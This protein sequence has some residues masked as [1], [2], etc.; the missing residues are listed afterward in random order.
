MKNYTFNAKQ[1]RRILI[2]LTLIITAVAVADHLP[3]DILQGPESADTEK[4]A[5]VLEV[6]TDPESVESVQSDTVSEEITSAA[7]T[8]ESAP[9]TSAPAGELP[10][11]PSDKDTLAV[12]LLGGCAPGSPLGTATFGSLNALI[13]R[14]GADY[15]FRALNALLTSDDLTI[16]A[17]NCVFTDTLPNGTLSCAAPAGNAEIYS[18]GSVEFLSLA[19]PIFTQ[20]TASETASALEIKNLKSGT[21]GS[22]AF[23]E[24][25]D[26]TL[27][28]YCTYLTKGH[29]TAQDL[30]ALRDAKG[31]SDY[32]IVFFWQ[33]ATLS[34]EPEEWM[35]Y[36]L[37]HFADEGASLIVGCGSNVLQP[38]ENYRESTIAYSIGTVL[39]G[40]SFLSDHS[41]A[42]LR[43]QLKRGTDGKVSSEILLIPCAPSVNRWQ[44]Y[45]LSDGER[46]SEVLA[47]LT[48]VTE[49]PLTDR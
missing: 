17:N 42:A 27:A 16:A 30:Q 46:K 22:T 14:E 40:T 28:V 35:R 31:K 13:N 12:T 43:L 44:P 7:Q 38:V 29:D 6:V 36:T 48:K 4:A 10:Y 23:F 32:L 19:S 15:C 20:N 24:I 11:P 18:S 8:T 3:A 47:Q 39:D 37:R 9:E 33:D 26:I 1:L 49:I 41:F 21:A 45:I 5:E 25:K 2:T 34:A